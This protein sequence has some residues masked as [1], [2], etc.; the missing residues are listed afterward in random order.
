MYAGG[1]RVAAALRLVRVL[2]RDAGLRGHG[3]A[4]PLLLGDVVLVCERL[5]L[6][7]GL[8]HVTR[9]H[10]R[11]ALG[12]AGARLLRREVLR[13]GLLGRLDRAGIVDAV[14]AA[15]GGFGR[16]EARLGRARSV[17]R[18]RGGV[19]RGDAVRLTWIRFL[20]SALV[21]SGWSLGVVKV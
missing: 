8:G 17:S 10:L 13:A 7:D 18:A 3:V 9:V 11:V 20:P 2:L 5:L 14:L 6:L 1:R 12:D 4:A 21:T 19:R 15:A 16:V